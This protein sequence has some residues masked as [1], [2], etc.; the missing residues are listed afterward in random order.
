MAGGRVL[1]V[2]VLADRVWVN[3]YDPVRQ[4]ELATYVEHSPESRSISEG[5]AFWWQ[6]LFGFWTPGYVAPFR[7]KPIRRIRETPVS[8]PTL[9]RL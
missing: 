8:R 1:E 2:I 9:P 6:G 7:D 4:G 5:D 3:T